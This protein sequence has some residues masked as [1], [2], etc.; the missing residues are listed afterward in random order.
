MKNDIIV[1]FIVSEDVQ[2]QQVPNT[3][4][5]KNIIINPLNIMRTRWIPTTMSLGITIVTSGIDFSKG[6]EIQ[7]TLVNRTSTAVI[8]DTGKTTIQVP[9]GNSDN[10]NFNLEL[11]NIAFEDPGFYDINLKIN[12]DSY[13]DHF[14]VLRNEDE[15]K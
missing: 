5:S 12:D 7:I 11:K 6:H 1:K 2:S 9:G 8:Y 3:P 15:H 10:F 13:S 4:I 14:K